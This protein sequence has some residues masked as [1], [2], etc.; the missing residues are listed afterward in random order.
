MV[1]IILQLSAI[2]EQQKIKYDMQRSVIG[3]VFV[4][5]FTLFV[6]LRLWQLR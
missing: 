2:S 1:Y 3:D 4:E 6:N 5:I